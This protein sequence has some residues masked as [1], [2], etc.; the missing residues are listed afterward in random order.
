[1]PDS[2]PLT[3]ESSPMSVYRPSLFATKECKHIFMKSGEDN[4]EWKNQFESQEPKARLVFHGDQQE[5]AY[6]QLA[7]QH[8][9]KIFNATW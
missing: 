7:R 4:Q 9:D 2:Y 1:M 3:V 6:H 8:S 5:A